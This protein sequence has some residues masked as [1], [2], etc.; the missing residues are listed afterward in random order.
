[1][2]K[3]KIFSMVSVA[4]LA[5]GMGMSS[6]ADKLD[7]A[8]IDYYGSGNFWTTEAQALGNI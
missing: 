1:M 4:L 6:C 7:L 3:N 5:A 8:P 2:K